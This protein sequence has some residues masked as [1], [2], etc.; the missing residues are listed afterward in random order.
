MRIVSLIFLT[1]PLA[2]TLL[3]PGCKSLTRTTE[4][5][6]QTRN[7]LDILSKYIRYAPVEIDIMPLT[8]F[9][10]GGKVQLNLYI[11]LIDSFGTQIKSPGKFRFELYEHVQR[12]PEPKGK[13]VAMWPDKSYIDQDEGYIDLSDT[14]KNHQYWRDF[15]RGYEFNLPLD[16]PTAQSY[17][18]QVTFLCPGGKRLLNEFIL[19]PTK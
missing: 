5:S 19:K 8:E 2:L 16:G 6:D 1:L 18:L 11:S 4:I 9:V 12:S 7:D 14:V 17:I 10:N 13:R 3:E 15:L